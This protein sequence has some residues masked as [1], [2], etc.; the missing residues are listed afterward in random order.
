[1][2]IGFL[3]LVLF[4]CS[5]PVAAQSG[6]RFTWSTQGHYN[7]DAPAA[8]GSLP[9]GIRFVVGNSKDRSSFG[10]GF[11]TIN[12]L[13]FAY[14]NSNVGNYAGN[15]FTHIYNFS[16]PLGISGG[17]SIAATYSLL[18]SVTYFAPPVTNHTFSNTLSQGSFDFRINT[19][20]IDRPAAGERSTEFNGSIFNVNATYN[21]L[22]TVFEDAAYSSGAGR[23]FIDS[24]GVGRNGARVE[25]YDSSGNFVSFTTTDAGG[26]YS[27]NNLSG[28]DYTVRVVW[29]SVTSTSPGSP[30]QTFRTNANNGTDLIASTAVDVTNRVG[31]EDTTKADAAAN[32]TGATLSSLT[33]SSE[34]AQSITP[35]KFTTDG[36]ANVDFGFHFYAA[37][38]LSLT[39]AVNPN[40]TVLP[41]TDLT[42]TATFTNNG[43][44][45]VRDLEFFNPIPNDTDF[46][47]GT[48]STS[49][50]STGLIPSISYSN[51]G[52][53]TFAYT[54]VS[55]AGGAPPGYDRFLTHIRF[56]FLGTLVP[57]A[58]N[59]QAS[60]SMV[61]RV[62]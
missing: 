14:Q 20:S 45:N 26:K 33:T 60:F 24:G 50:G 62:R 55:G 31:G 34:T 2:R 13:E 56:Y 21:V 11:V 61:A 9:P 18:G 10:F 47:V 41:G 7:S 5:L 49:V 54:P 16:R 12:N 44:V 59:N 30:K 36:V 37:P 51:N 38:S 22:G 57:T 32:T 39:N 15:T 28:G 4:L 58:P 46:K 6:V 53:A 29:S 1:M 17:Q 3:L 35:V 23:N 48:A 40:G 19:L 42:Y 25:L 8:T 43:S 27:F 52:G